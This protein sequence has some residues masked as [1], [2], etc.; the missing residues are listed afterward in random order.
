L[1][2]LN[3]N[4]DNQFSA[5]LPVDTEEHIFPRQVHSSAFSRAIPKQTAKPQL[6][7]SSLDVASLIGLNTEQL[8]SDEFLQLFTGNFVPEGISPYAMCYGGHQF[9]HWAGQLGD[10]RAINLAEIAT[11]DHGHKV[12]QL[13][14]AGPTPYSR[15]ADGLAVLRSSIREFLCSESMYHLGIPTTRALSLSLTGD[16]VVRDMFYNGNAKAELGAV[17][18]RVSSSFMRF[19]SIELPAYRKD[20]A[21]LKQLVDYSIKRDFPQLLKQ[22]ADDPIKRYLAWFDEIAQRTCR[23]MVH[24]M[25]V[26]FVHGVMNTDNMSL[27]GET[28][29]YGP[30][31]WIDNFDLSWTPNTTDAQGKR[32]S[33]GKQGEI[34]QWNLFQLANAIYPLIEESSPLEAILNNYSKEYQKQ[35]HEMMS[36]KLGISITA[37]ED[38]NHKADT[39]LFLAL[40]TLL[41]D[42]ETDMTIFYRLLADFSY[43]DKIKENNVAHFSDCFY[44]DDQLTTEHQARFSSWLENYTNRLQG[45]NKTPEQRKSAMNKVNPKYVL[46]NYLAQQAIELAE[47]GDFSKLHELQKVLEKP[48]DEQIEFHHYSEKRPEWARNKAGCSMLSCSS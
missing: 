27:I 15:T 33:F 48:Y 2:Y 9:G 42:I 23:L 29:D 26:G 10:G 36:K 31:G 32:Y 40:E 4:F 39:T 44:L 43:D 38:I 13:K 41:G 14:G 17:V 20:K 16:S 8:Q 3:F 24:W 1:S 46:R 35:W 5:Q 7:A 45:D 12:L 6:I 19:G 18:C 34:S 22:Y 30:Y 37:A 11:P 47:Q 28:I 21:L 25:R